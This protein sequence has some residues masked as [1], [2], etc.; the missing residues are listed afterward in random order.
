MSEKVDN[1]AEALKFRIAD[2]PN[3]PLAA[4]SPNRPLLFSIVLVGGGLCGF[5]LALAL[6]FI[7]PTVMST[8]QLRQ[9]TGLPV[10]GSVSLKVTEDKVQKNKKD[11]LRYSF[12]GVGLLVIYV[13]FMALELMGVRFFS[14]SKLLQSIT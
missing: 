8:L 2:A 14:L 5:G 6:Y 7:R 3:K 1:Q 10:L 4:S 9:L 11:R 13:G 12:A